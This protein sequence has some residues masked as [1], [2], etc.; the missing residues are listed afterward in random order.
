MSNEEALKWIDFG[1]PHLSVRRQCELL[2]I[3]RSRL[4]YEPVPETPDNLL[5]MRLID[6]QYMETPFW[7]SR[8]MTT[9]LRGP[10]HADFQPFHTLN[11]SYQL[12]VFRTG[13]SKAPLATD[14]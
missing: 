14:Y 10:R 2:R 5:Y 9:F 7:G 4:Y 11:L 12:K 13:S 6:K 8:N 1:D 3:H